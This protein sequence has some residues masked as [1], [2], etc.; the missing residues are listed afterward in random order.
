MD[1]VR[2]GWVRSPPPATP[3]RGWVSEAPNGRNDRSKAGQPWGGAKAVPRRVG[4]T[5]QVT[6]IDFS[7]MPFPPVAMFTVEIAAPLT[8]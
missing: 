1:L 3:E 4:P 7:V 5:D 8:K 6:V 2:A